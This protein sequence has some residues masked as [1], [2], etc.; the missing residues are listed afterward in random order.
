[1]YKDASSGAQHTVPSTLHTLKNREREL[2]LRFLL[3]FDRGRALSAEALDTCEDWML[4]ELG[5]SAPVLEYAARRKAMAATVLT[6][7]GWERDFLEFDNREEYL[8]NI[9]G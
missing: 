4:T 1:V 2:V 7:S 6:E 9:Y 3:L 5:T 8:P